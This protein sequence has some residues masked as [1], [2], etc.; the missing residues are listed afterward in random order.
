MTKGYIS[1]EAL[2]TSLL[3]GLGFLLSILAVRYLIILIKYIDKKLQEPSKKK[4]W[5]N[6]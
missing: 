6:E 5:G 1:P 2:G 3:I 4:S